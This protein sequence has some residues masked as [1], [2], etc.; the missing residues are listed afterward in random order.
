MQ[1]KLSLAA[2]LAVAASFTFGGLYG[3]GDAAFGYLASVR[4]ALD[5]NTPLPPAPPAPPRIENLVSGRNYVV[6]G[7]SRW[8][9][10]VSTYERNVAIDRVRYPMFGAA[11]ANIYPCA[12][13]PKPLEKQVLPSDRGPH[14]VLMVQNDRDPATPL[15][16]ARTMRRAFGDRAAML[17]VD[18]GGHGTYLFGKNT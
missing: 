11:A 13:W 1:K 18:Q 10:S 16:G 14:N 7:D 15:A 5:T 4:K 3:T 2:V 17:T 6:C 9:S 8:P 12:F